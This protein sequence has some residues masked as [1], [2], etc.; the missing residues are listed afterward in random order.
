VRVGLLLQM[1][2]MELLEEVGIYALVI[3]ASEMIY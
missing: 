3:N 2:I 1:G